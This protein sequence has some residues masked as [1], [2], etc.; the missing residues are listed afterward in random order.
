MVEALRFLARPRRKKPALRR[1]IA[2]LLAAR[3]ETSIIETVFGNAGLDEFEFIRCLKLA[4][5]GNEEACL[6]VTEIAAAVVPHLTIS[7]GPK[8]SAE[9][10]AHEYFLEEMVSRINP[11]HYTWSNDEGDFSDPVTRA[12]RREFN[13]NDFDPRLRQSS[14]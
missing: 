13:D 3:E 1:R 4:D 2:V 12:T 11:S 14:N 5:E 8:I 6:R 9:S 10:I 7:C